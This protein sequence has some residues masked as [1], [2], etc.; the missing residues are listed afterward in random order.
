MERVEISQRVIA[1]L[2]EILDEPDGGEKLAFSEEMKLFH[3]GLAISSI[4][5][6][7]FIIRLEEIFGIHWPDDLITFDNVLTIGQVIDVVELCI[8]QE[9][10]SI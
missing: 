2:E 7:S 3:A 9:G 10:M 5:G 4:D 1:A 6:V 8:K